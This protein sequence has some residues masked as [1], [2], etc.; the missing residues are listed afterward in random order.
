MGF[1]GTR[2]LGSRV[3]WRAP[4]G[5]AIPAEPNFAAI[6]AVIPRF[7]TSWVLGSSCR[8]PVKTQTALRHL[9]PDS[10]KLD[11]WLRLPLATCG[12]F[13]RA[14]KREGTLDKAALAS[15]LDD[16]APPGAHPGATPTVGPPHQDDAHRCRTQQ[17]PFKPEPATV[18]LLFRG[19]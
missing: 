18:N 3:T 8:G 17:L 2:R 10:D 16:R 13:T 7:E 15:T 9:R 19:S 5:C 11:F 12:V 1:S 6:H 4:Y 14:R